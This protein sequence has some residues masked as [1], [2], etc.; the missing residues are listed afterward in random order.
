[1][2]VRAAVVAAT[3]FAIT[4]YVV[5]SVADS[6]LKALGDTASWAADVVD[7]AHEIA[8]QGWAR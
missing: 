2:T 1:M 4:Y 7:S 5:D 8:T 6:M 3:A